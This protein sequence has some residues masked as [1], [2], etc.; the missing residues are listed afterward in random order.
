MKTES[1]PSYRISEQANRACEA[2]VERLLK[3]PPGK[4]VGQ[5]EF[6]DP[7]MTL[8]RQRIV[9]A[10]PSGIKEEDFIGITELFYYT[11]AATDS[12][13]HVYYESARK[14][15][16]PW[17]GEDGLTGKL[18]VPDEHE[19][20][21]PFK[22][23]LLAFGQS[24]EEINRKTREVQE[25]IYDH[26]SGST[27]VHLMYFGTDQEYFTQY[28]YGV[29]IPVLQPGL[30]DSAEKVRRV[31]GRESLHMG[32]FGDLAAILVADNQD[33]LYRLVECA[34]DLNMPGKQLIPHLVNQSGRWIRQMGGDYREV[35]RQAVRLTS[36]VVGHNPENLGTVA[37]GLTAKKAPGLLQIPARIL[38]FASKAP[39]LGHE[40]KYIA[41]QAVQEREGMKPRTGAER[42]HFE[43]TAR[44]R[45][46]AVDLLA[47]VLE[48]YFLQDEVD[49][50]DMSEAA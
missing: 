25:K 29:Y 41:G 28:V 34:S 46:P 39:V 13:A 7:L 21:A 6:P 22:A 31:R 48:P 3:N 18:W 42:G 15:D 12:Y 24:E 27:P 16:A 35:E 4:F 2:Y 49:E 10:L 45:K 14:Y 20:K 50:P 37:I 9:A 5:T 32:W 47:R 11:E 36:K 30:P 19:H 26:K 1:G 23:V 8:D 43:R 40:I 44:I 38:E 17:L 33:S